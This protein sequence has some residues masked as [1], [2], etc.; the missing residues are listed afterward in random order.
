[1]PI[2]QETMMRFVNPA[3]VALTGY[4][5]EELQAMTFWDVIHPD[6]RDLIR[7]RGMQRQQGAPVPQRYEVKLLTRT[8][9]ERWV[10]YMG[11][12]IQYEGKPAVLGIV[13]DITDRIRTETALR[14]TEERLSMVI[15]HAPIYLWAINKE[16]VYTLA[17][18]QAMETLGLRPGELVGRSFF[19][20]NRDQPDL[21]SH[22]YR[23]LAGEAF[24][25][26]VELVQGV[27]FETNY[28]PMRDESGVVAGVLGISVN[29]TGRDPSTT[30]SA[31]T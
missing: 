4:T 14:H 2:F 22:I 23:A 25:A 30:V 26:Y 17:E 18:G 27:I 15:S 16:G 20:V 3:A 21:Q 29:V 11:T 19:E 9:E 6:M 24:S 1:M 10:D 5:L 13:F 8:G 12:I 7:E 28:L 31:G